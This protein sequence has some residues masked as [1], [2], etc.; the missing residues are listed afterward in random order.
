M[1]RFFKSYLLLQLLSGAQLLQE[2]LPAGAK[3]L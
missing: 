1:F 3:P 2:Q